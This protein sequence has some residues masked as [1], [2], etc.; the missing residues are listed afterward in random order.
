[1]LGLDHNPVIAPAAVVGTDDV[2]PLP[3]GT[4]RAEPVPPAQK[5]QPIP[6][7]RV[8]IPVIMVVAIG[9]VMALM[10]L[11][12]RGVSPMMLMFPLMMLVGMIAMFN[13]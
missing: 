5:D 7:I 3:A 9:A 10:A 11:S 4:L 13:P 8:L 2:P 6:L 1:M 12:G